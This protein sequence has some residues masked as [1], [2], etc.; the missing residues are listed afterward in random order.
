MTNRYDTVDG[1]NIVLCLKYGRCMKAEHLVGI[2][3]R[4]PVY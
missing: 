1:D 3:L 4:I 2:S